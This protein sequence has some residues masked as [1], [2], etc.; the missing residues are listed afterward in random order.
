MKQIPGIS[1]NPAGLQHQLGTTE[2]RTFREW[3][4]L[5]FSAFLACPWP[6]LNHLPYSTQTN[7]RNR[8]HPL[9]ANSHSTVS[10]TDCLFPRGSVWTWFSQSYSGNFLTVA[11]QQGF[12][13]KRCPAEGTVTSL[14]VFK[15]STLHRPLFFALWPVV[16]LCSNLSVLQK[17]AS[18]TRAESCTSV[19]SVRTH[20]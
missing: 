17:E 12:R 7:L 15:S 20:K 16:D 11:N 5:A 6:L 1:V 4:M 19:L 13:S 10:V 18:P 9:I 3:E 14:F 2:A 8:L